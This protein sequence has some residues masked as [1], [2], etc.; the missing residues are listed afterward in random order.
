MTTTMK[1]QEYVEKFTCF[2]ELE[3]WLR[4]K[5]ENGY[6]YMVMQMQK[7][8]IVLHVKKLKEWG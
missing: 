2:P 4:P 7:N 3:T 5:I 6:V 1:W 8:C